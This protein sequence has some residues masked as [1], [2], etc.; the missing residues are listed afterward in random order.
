MAFGPCWSVRTQWRTPDKFQYW[1]TGVCS[2]LWLK[3]WLDENLNYYWCP[4]KV[5]QSN[6]QN[7]LWDIIQLFSGP[8]VPEKCTSVLLSTEQKQSLFGRTKMKSTWIQKRI[9]LPTL[10]NSHTTL[11]WS[12]TLLWSELI[13]SSGE[14]NTQKN[15]PCYCFSLRLEKWSFQLAKKVW[16][17]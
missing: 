15:Q 2:L 13:F 12:T 7:F 10:I 17:N 8:K 3:S 11:N 6:K 14:K 16:N 9:F 1:L 5:T 4:E